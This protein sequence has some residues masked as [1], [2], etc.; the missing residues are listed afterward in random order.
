MQ[1]ATDMTT[2]ADTTAAQDTAQEA[3][4]EASASQGAPLMDLHALTH[5]QLLA[6]IAELGQPKFRAKQNEEWIWEKNA[7]SF[8]DMTNL[9]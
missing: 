2:N 7:Q 3:A 1:D 9:P 8:D 6:L 4:Q 5:G